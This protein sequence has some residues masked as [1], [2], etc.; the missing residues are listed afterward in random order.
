MVRLQSVTGPLA[1][2]SAAVLAR[3]ILAVLADHGIKAS[4]CIPGSEDFLKA[5]I[6]AKP[7]DKH[8]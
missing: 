1:H 8:A 5:R 4:A 6:V 3:R 2:D 7:K